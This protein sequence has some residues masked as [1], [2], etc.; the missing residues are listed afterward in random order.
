MSQTIQLTGEQ[1][2]RKLM[3][4]EQSLIVYA[5]V[6]LMEYPLKAELSMDQALHECETS[7]TSFSEV[8]IGEGTVSAILNH[9]TTLGNV[10]DLNA[11]KASFE[12]ELAD[13]RTCTEFEYRFH[14]GK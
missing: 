6:I 11:L 7:I 2:C 1:V 14:I 5:V 12:K 8:L 10:E 4:E 3:G 13:L 9:P